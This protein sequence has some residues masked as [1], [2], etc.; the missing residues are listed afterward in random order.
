[1]VRPKPATNRLSYGAA[2]TVQYIFSENLNS[3]R[4]IAMKLIIGTFLDPPQI[5]SR[6][7]Y[8]S[9]F[10]DD[11]WKDTEQIASHDK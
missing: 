8:A 5:I 9:W 10:Y 4:V 2:D 1:M 3:E 6:E 7:I 11:I